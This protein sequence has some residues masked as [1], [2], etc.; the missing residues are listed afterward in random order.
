MELTIEKDYLEVLLVRASSISVSSSRYYKSFLLELVGDRLRIVRADGRERAVMVSTDKFT[1]IDDSEP[2][3][4]LIEEVLFKNLVLGIPSGQ[5]TLKVSA[6]DVFEIKGEG[7]SGKWIGL[8]LSDFPSFPSPPEDFNPIELNVK[9]FTAGLRRVAYASSKEAV[10]LNQ[11]QIVFR[12]DVCWATDSLKFQEVSISLAKK[13]LCLVFPSSGADVL[14]FLSWTSEET[15][16]FGEHEGYLF[17]VT[18]AGVFLCRDPV[19]TPIDKES[20]LESV[21]GPEEQQGAFQV[22]VA[23][24]TQLVKRV[25]LTSGGKGTVRFDIKKDEIAVSSKDEL[26]SVGKEAW[27]TALTG[28]TKCKRKFEVFW[29]RLLDALSVIKDKSAEVRIDERHI[30]LKSD[31]SFG[32]IPMYKRQ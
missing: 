22:D 13:K 30:I 27:K 15:V 29:S 26:G 17:F 32:V 23:A 5:L 2:K 12:E 28:N 31:D 14:A 7:Y 19:V 25:S 16:K 11:R 6:D 3:R 18:K 4:V 10:Q 1:I 8:G 9:N 20:F 24:F 21:L